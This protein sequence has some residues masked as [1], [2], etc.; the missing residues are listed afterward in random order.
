MKIYFVMQC[1]RF[2]IMCLD[3]ADGGEGAS[4]SCDACRGKTGVKILQKAIL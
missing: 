3:T 1:L 4:R 2:L